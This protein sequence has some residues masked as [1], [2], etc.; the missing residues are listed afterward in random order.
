VSVDG[1]HPVQARGR[2]LTCLIVDDSTAFL[3]AARHLLER[4]G[5]V[6]VGGVSNPDEAVARVRDLEP[7]VALVDIDLN[8]ASGFD[9]VEGIAALGEH[10]PPVILVSAY[11]ATDYAELVEESGAVGF[12]SKTALSA[13]AIA[14]LLGAADEEG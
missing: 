8:G 13:A 11:A 9:V 1:A 6:V 3:S 14:E 12:I 7:D 4:E 10:A 5:I 2:P